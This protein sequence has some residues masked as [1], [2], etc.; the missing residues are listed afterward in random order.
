MNL[1][2]NQIKIIFFFI[3]TYTLMKKD[4]NIFQTLFRKVKQKES[5]NSQ[6]SNIISNYGQVTCILFCKTAQYRE[7]SPTPR[8]IHLTSLIHLQA[9]DPGISHLLEIHYPQALLC[10][11][12]QGTLLTC[13]LSLNKY[14]PEQEPKPSSQG[15]QPL[16]WRGITTFL[17]HQS[18]TTLRGDIVLKVSMPE[19]LCIVKVQVQILSSRGWKLLCTSNIQV[20]WFWFLSWC[21]KHSGRCS[22]IHPENCISTITE[23]LFYYFY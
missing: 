17:L 7:L 14:N 4:W 13:S 10:L 9:A 8:K 2:S 21:R 15:R 22:N 19:V 5:S 6:L 18:R 3:C 1:S 23:L 20:E 11:L 16:D 12:K